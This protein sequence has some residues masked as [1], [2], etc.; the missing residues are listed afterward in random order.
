MTPLVAACGRTTVTHQGLISICRNA[1]IQAKNKLT[2]LTW[3]YAIYRGKQSIKCAA[4]YFL[5][6]KWIWFFGVCGSVP[7]T[8]LSNWRIKELNKKT[9]QVKQKEEIHKAKDFF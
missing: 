6:N 4:V 1:A 9:K 8:E 5:Q 3:V 2:S 7:E